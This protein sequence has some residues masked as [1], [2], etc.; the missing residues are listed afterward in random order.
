[1]FGLL[2]KIIPLDLASTLSPGIFALVI[3]LLGSK[4]HPKLRAFYLL[5]GSLIVGIGIAFFGLSL[6]KLASIDI[7]PSAIA[8]IVDLLFGFLFII[9][10]IKI[11]VQKERKIKLQQERQKYE[12]LKLL[13]AGIVISATNFDAV[14][15]SFTAAK[16]VGLSSEIGDLAK[17][18]LLIVNILFFILPISLPLFLSL[19]LPEFA[20]HILTKINQF[21]LKYSKYLIFGLFIIFGIIFVYRSLKFFI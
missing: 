4:F 10:G 14:I 6:G 1:M 8:A 19:I 12:I 7:K 20:A 11:L 21:V 17:L 13:L 2:A 16:E 5:L 3:V 18:I 15:L 9:L